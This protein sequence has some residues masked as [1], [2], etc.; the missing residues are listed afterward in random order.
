MH[1]Q[2]IKGFYPMKKPEGRDTGKGCHPL[3]TGW[4]Q[5]F[6]DLPYKPFRTGLWHT[7][8]ARVG[9]ALAWGCFSVGGPWSALLGVFLSHSGGTN[10]ED[11]L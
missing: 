7:E 4:S 10:A 8:G 9:R 2:G 1:S 11:F 5:Q 3:A 6:R